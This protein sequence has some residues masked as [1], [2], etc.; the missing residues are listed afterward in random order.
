MASGS[1]TPATVAGPCKGTWTMRCGAGALGVLSLRRAAWLRHSSTSA[2]APRCSRVSHGWPLA[3][4]ILL[5]H[6]VHDRLEHRTVDVGQR[7]PAVEHAVV[8][9][10][11]EPQ[12]P[13]RASRGAVFGGGR[14][15]FAD[16]VRRGPRAT[17][18][19][20][21]RPSV[22]LRRDPRPPTPT[23]GRAAPRRASPSPRLSPAWAASATD[24]RSRASGAHRAS[25]S[26]PCRPTSRRPPPAHRA[27][28]TRRAPPP[29]GAAAP[30]PATR[31]AAASHSVE[32]HRR[33]FN[34]SW[35]SNPE[36][37][38]NVCSSMTPSSHGG[39][40][41]TRRRSE[42]ARRWRGTRRRGT[43]AP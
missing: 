42:G 6:L 35:K 5:D 14:A 11:P 12:L 17:S 31:A 26:R 21:P 4:R 22:R 24:S 10:P 25:G 2:S 27:P 15:L 18:P 8:G 40:T 38:S 20:H 23:R 30:A 3:G 1:G 39:V 29:A 41:A 43:R 13:R 28:P 32:W 16:L 7:E 34:R 9:S 37:K 33:S 19:A 36:S